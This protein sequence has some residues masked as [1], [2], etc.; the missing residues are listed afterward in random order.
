MAKLPIHQTKLVTRTR[1]LG[2]KLLGLC[3]ENKDRDWVRGRQKGG[4]EGE[5]L[6]T[7]RE[8]LLVIL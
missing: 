3:P 6:Q 8:R 4:D 1:L 2:E 5:P 7:Y